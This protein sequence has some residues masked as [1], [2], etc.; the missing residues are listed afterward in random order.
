MG[1]KTNIFLPVSYDKKITSWKSLLLPSFSRAMSPV[2]FQMEKIS[3]LEEAWGKEK[4]GLTQPS[5]E[6]DE[7]SCSC[8]GFTFSPP[9]WS[10]EEKKESANSP[11]VTSGP[12]SILVY[13]VLLKHSHATVSPIVCGWFCV[14]AA[15]P[16]RVYTTF[17]A[18]NICHLALYRRKRVHHRQCRTSA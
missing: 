3:F 2:L 9:Q 4:E 1:Y 13:K 16:N 6:K 15:E 5:I 8:S 11:W 18:E 17:K 12:L 14:T 10:L 7:S